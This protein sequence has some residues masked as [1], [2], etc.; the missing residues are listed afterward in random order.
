MINFLLKKFTNGAETIDVSTRDACG[1]KCSAV[2]IACNIVLFVVKIIVGIMASSIAI[3][4]DAINNLSDAGSSVIILIGFKLSGKPADE[5]H[6][7]GHARMEYIAGLIVSFLVLILGFSLFKD[8][9]MKIIS[10]SATSF[11]LIPIIILAVAVLIKL[12][13]CAFYKTA[14]RKIK[15]SALNAASLDS[16]NDAIASAAV[17]AAMLIGYF[18]NVNLDGYMGAA[19]AIFIIISGIGIVKDTMSPLLGEAPDDDMVEL[20]QNKLSQYP[21]IIGMHDLMAH[22]Y[23]P[24]RYYVSVHAEMDASGN[25]LACHDL[26]DNIEQEMLKEGVH[27]VIHLDP[28]VTNDAEVTRVYRLIKEI[29]SDVDEELVIHDFRIVDGDMKKNLLFDVVVP[30]RFKLTND[31]LKNT[32]CEK[33]AKLDENFFPIIRIDEKYAGITRKKGM[34]K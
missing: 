27:L 30:H 20:V 11:E 22:S 4:A 14:S 34:K 23:G 3:T 5:D 16:R 28:I 26:I 15:S 8:S 17:I 24:G 31:E 9:V 19:V 2:G 29:V 10:P 18:Y 25:L 1:R 33:I 6:P 7:Y 32:I 12:W 13:M 21:E